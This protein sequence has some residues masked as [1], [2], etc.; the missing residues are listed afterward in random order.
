MT[1]LSD[2][3]AIILS[4]AAQ[5]EDRIALVEA[6]SKAQGMWRDAGSADPVFTDLL[7]LDLGDVVSE[8]R[9]H[10][11]K[12]APAGVT[13]YVTGPA[14]FSA[15]LVAAFAVPAVAELLRRPR[16]PRPQDAGASR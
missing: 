10:L 15:D 7:E 6:Y 2:T 13:V 9:T 11:D 5:R 1:K 14:G 8:I 3:Q 4:S 16:S 12:A